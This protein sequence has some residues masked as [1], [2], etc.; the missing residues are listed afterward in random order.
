MIEST[1]ESDDI[2]IKL[3]IAG[4]DAAFQRLVLRYQDLVAGLIWRLV[5]GN[6][7]REEICQDI[8]VKVYFNLKKFR[9][10]SKFSTW[11][12]TVTYRTALS[13]L[14]KRRLSTE[15][16]DDQLHAGTVALDTQD[17][18]TALLQREIAQLNIDE[19][20][21]ITLYHIHGC[22]VEEISGIT[23]RPV[24]TVKNLLFRVRRKLKKR[25]E[26]KLNDEFEEVS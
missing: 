25:L 20:T 18:M 17:E 16:F 23:D 13:F 8:F 2:L 7:D 3:A 6:E 22:S 9:F 14:R 24:G 15:P 19:R 5:R 21:V 4:S 11:L 12:Y 10:D 1:E 26:M